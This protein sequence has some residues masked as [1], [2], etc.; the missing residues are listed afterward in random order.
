MLSLNFIFRNDA[1]GSPDT[2]EY[3]KIF[4]NISNLDVFQLKANMDLYSLPYSQ[5]EGIEKLRLNL[6][7]YLLE[8][9]LKTDHLERN[10]FQTCLVETLENLSVGRSVGYPCVFVG[11]KYQAPKH[12]SF[13]IHLKR[14]HPNIKNIRCNFRKMCKRNFSVVDDLIVHVKQE[15]TGQ[16]KE[17][18]GSVAV[19][20]I[21]VPCKCDRISCG[22]MNFPSTKFS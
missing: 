15:H 1:L 21:D 7:K 10:F 14:N 12:R 9:I 4:H 13:I 11:C 8:E 3:E 19:E 2:T 6:K 18:A 20:E 5:Y 17:Q 16:N 22:G